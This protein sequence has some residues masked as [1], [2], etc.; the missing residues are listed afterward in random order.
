MY[1]IYISNAIPK[2]PHTLHHPL[3]HPP[4]HTSWAWR[5]PVLKHIKFAQLLGLSFH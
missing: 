2:F 4:T 5:S 1:F 3:P